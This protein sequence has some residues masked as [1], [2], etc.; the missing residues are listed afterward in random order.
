M[1]LIGVMM[2]VPAKAYLNDLAQQFPKGTT[3]AQVRAAYG[4]QD[5]IPITFPQPGMS[6]FMYPSGLG[7]IVFYFCNKVLVDTTETISDDGDLVK[8]RHLVEEN[9]KVLGSGA[10]KIAGQTD[11]TGRDW[12][13]IFVGWNLA[14]GRTARLNVTQYSG[15]ALSLEQEITDSRIGNCLTK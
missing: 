14:D 8:F 5:A 4:A 9:S 3:E 6:G 2:A 13:Q 1:T 12:T 7:K 10:P 11:A 15:G